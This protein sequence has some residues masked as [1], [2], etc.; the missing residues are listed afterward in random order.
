MCDGAA[1]ESRPLEKTLLS[2]ECKLSLSQSGWIGLA[3]FLLGRGGEGRE[4]VFN[5]SSS[6]LA[7]RKRQL[8]SSQ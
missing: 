2:K 3:F 1:A 7:T 8:L 4:C 5:L 6:R